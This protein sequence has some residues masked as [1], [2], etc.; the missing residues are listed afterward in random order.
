L[1]W[2]SKQARSARARVAGL[3]HCGS[4]MTGG[5]LRFL[6]AAWTLRIINTRTTRA[7]IT[8]RICL[9]L[10]VNLHTSD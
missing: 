9:I 7:P 5:L 4:E 8:P 1:L 6:A 2:Q 3:F 10:I